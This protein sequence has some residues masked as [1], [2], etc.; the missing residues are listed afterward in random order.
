LKF[1]KALQAAGDK[2]NALELPDSH[3]NVVARVEKRFAITTPCH[4]VS[5]WPLS[6]RLCGKPQKIRLI[7]IAGGVIS[8]LGAQVMLI[9]APPG[10]ADAG[11]T[12]S[13][14]DFL[15]FGSCGT[16]SPVVLLRVT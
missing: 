1:D 3:L 15:H 2:P 16:H 9:R 14:F 5:P 11:W 10:V 4:S 12:N 6:P 7:G 13:G 8:G